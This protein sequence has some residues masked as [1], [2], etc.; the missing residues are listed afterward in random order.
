M[1]LE[2]FGGLFGKQQELGELQ[3]GAIEGANV[4]NWRARA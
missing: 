4:Q 2:S 3:F 1:N